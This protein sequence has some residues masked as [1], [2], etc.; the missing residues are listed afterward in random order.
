MLQD[1]LLSRPWTPVAM[2]TPSQPGTADGWWR[3]ESAAFVFN[4]G[5]F[6]LWIWVGVGA[7]PAPLLCFFSSRYKL[8]DSLDCWLLVAVVTVNPAEGRA[9]ITTMMM[10]MMKHP[11]WLLNK[12]CTYVPPVSEFTACFS[13][14]PSS[15]ASWELADGQESCGLA[16]DTHMHTHAHTMDQGFSL[17]TLVSV[18]RV[19]VLVCSGVVALMR[20]CCF[21]VIFGDLL[22]IWRNRI[23]R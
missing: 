20:S 1:L 17:N 12:D 23:S 5:F 15:E 19:C 2:V 6:G 13:C 16:S 11:N 14:L 18:P 7:R 10:M 21:L 22:K 9:G 4:L 3:N 8:D